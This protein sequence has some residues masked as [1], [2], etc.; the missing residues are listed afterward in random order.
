MVIKMLNKAEYEILADF[1]EDY[2]GTLS[3][4]MQVTVAKINVIVTF[5][6][7]QDAL[8][9]DEDLYLIWLKRYIALNY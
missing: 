6:D 1:F 4:D 5:N 9:D 7:A 2:T 8:Y 3:A